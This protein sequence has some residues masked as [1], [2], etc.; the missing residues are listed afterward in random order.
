[1]LFS[2]FSD[3]V[4]QENNIKCSR[5]ILKREIMNFNKKSFLLNNCMETSLDL[6]G[7]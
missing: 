5:T 6:K 2:W 1:M 7:D 4:Q 3:I